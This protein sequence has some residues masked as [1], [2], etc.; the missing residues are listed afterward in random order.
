[1]KNRK[2]KRTVQGAASLESDEARG[3]RE[4]VEE[5][6]RELAELDRDIA[7]AKIGDKGEMSHVALESFCAMRK[8][9]VEMIASSNELYKT[10]LESDELER[11]L[12]ENA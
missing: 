6:E 7:E 5:M 1:M 8:D 12:E 2:T 10:V 4:S 11:Q 9:I 3:I